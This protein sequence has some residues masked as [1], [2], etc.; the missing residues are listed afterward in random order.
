MGEGRLGFLQLWGRTLE[1][2]YVKERGN[3]EPLAF[4]YAAFGNRE[5]LRAGAGNWELGWHSPP[6]A[7]GSSPAPCSG[8]GFKVIKQLWQLIA[9]HRSSSRDLDFWVM[10]CSASWDAPSIPFLLTVTVIKP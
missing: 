1:A 8:S 9:G 10:M 4:I 2:F 6:P 5:G 3:D 7:Q